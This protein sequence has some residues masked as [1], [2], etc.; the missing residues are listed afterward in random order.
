MTKMRVWAEISLENIKKNLQSVREK[1]SDNTKLCAV[2]KADGYGHGAT[3]IA[4]YTEDIVDSFAVATIDEA[5]QLRKAGVKCDILI[6][7]YILPESYET[8]IENDI[9]LTVISKNDAEKISGAAKKI[10]KI[11]KIHIGID[12]GM[13]RI[14]FDMSE[15]S[16][17][18][19]SEI[20]KLEGVFTEGIF[21][22][23]ATADE[24]NKEY[25]LLQ[26][27]RYDLFC[28]KLENAAHI[29]R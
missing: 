23:F 9:T 6:L 15:E 10:G 25:A 17:L 18:E 3:E 13:G 12:T 27:E 21:T 8:A 28:E 29:F 20:T 11:G 5:M 26:K 22:H 24:K 4:K 14:G 2:I 19:I 16:V 1:L 7:G